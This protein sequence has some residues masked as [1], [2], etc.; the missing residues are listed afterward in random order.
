MCHRPVCSCKCCVGRSRVGCCL[1]GKRLCPGGNDHE[2]ILLSF[3]ACSILVGCVSN[4][5]L[6]VQRSR[7][8][9]HKFPPCYPVRRKKVALLQRGQ[10]LPAERPLQNPRIAII[11]SAPFTN[12]GLSPLA[13]R[14]LICG[15]LSGRLRFF[16]GASLAKC[17]GRRG[18]FARCRSRKA[19][20]DSSWGS[21][22]PNQEP[23]GL[24]RQRAAL[25]V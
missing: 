3:A 25:E 19:P 7:H 4:A 22:H 8:R 14:A 13:L 23:E 16:F 5:N 1:D 11:A 18:D 17:W 21:Q 20:Q 15:P 24:V 9:S 2:A 10:H 12:L 6:Q